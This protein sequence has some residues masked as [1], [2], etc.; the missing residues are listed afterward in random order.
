MSFDDFLR[1][2]KY[3]LL[4][5]GSSS[6]E[7]FLLKGKQAKEELLTW[8]RYQVSQY[9]LIMILM[10]VSWFQGQSTFSLPHHWKNELRLLFWRKQCMISSIGKFLTLFPNNL[11]IEATE[12]NLVKLKK[13][14]GLIGFSFF[15]HFI[16]F[17]LPQF[18]RYM[19]NFVVLFSLFFIPAD[20]IPGFSE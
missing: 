8:L 15:S 3:N 5:M 6:Y 17:L 2:S 12:R 11:C 14:P 18:S 16:C 13:Q 10:T 4:I 7:S 20:S 1:V 19:Q 9:S